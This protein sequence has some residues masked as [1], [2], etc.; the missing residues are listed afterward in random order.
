MERS[1][2]LPIVHTQIGPQQSP[3]RS[4]KPQTSFINPCDLG[5]ERSPARSQPARRLKRY[6]WHAR[7]Q[8][9]QEFLDA[10]LIQRSNMLRALTAAAAAAAALGAGV[11]CRFAL[12]FDCPALSTNESARQQFL[13]LV[14]AAEGAG[15][16]QPGVGYDAETAFT[17]DGHPL[18]YTDGTLSLV[19]C[20]VQ[21]SYARVDARACRCRK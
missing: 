19:Q 18:N 4:R 2:P 20:S 1:T 11:R 15:F 14:M 13:Q 5:F 8:Q 17:F 21:G 10:G 6:R 16:H 12:D 7:W 9:D 3:V